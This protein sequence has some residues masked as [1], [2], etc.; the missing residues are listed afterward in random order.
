M[1]ANTI[2]QIVSI[3]DKTLLYSTWLEGRL[4]PESQSCLQQ[5]AGNNDAQNVSFISFAGLDPSHSLSLFRT[6]MHC[7]LCSALSVTDGINV[8]ARHHCAMS[9]FNHVVP[10][11][12]ALS[13][14]LTSPNTFTHLQ[15]TV[16]GSSGDIYFN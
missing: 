11:F 16:L 4:F 8:C 7:D 2:L 13:S 10:V 1:N 5:V 14:F 3:K 12:Q 15:N 9:L 6:L